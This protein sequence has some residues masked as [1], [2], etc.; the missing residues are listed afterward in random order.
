MIQWRGKAAS[1]LLFH[2]NQGEMAFL[3]FF[4][5]LFSLDCVFTS[6]L[7][8]LF[9]LVS[10]PHKGLESLGGCLSNWPS[11]VKLEEDERYVPVQLTELCRIV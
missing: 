2:R 8:K 3:I 6:G 10:F 4:F 9:Q 5:F 11:E 1:V 7:T